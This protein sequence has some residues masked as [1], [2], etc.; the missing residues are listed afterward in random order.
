MLRIKPVRGVGAALQSE[1]AALS[2]APKDVTGA[3]SILIVNLYDPILMPDGEQEIAVIGGLHDRV[4]VRP[5][6][7]EIGVAVDI[8]MVKRVPHP[9]RLQVGVEID[10]R[11]TQHRRNTGIAGEVREWLCRIYKTEP[12]AVK[13]DHTMSWCM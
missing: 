3:F 1:I 7:E 13:K 4:G 11:V 8:Q 12:M 6:R 5:V 10:E 9:N 2:Q